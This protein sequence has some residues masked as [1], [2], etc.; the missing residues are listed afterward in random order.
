MSRDS[1]TVALVT[2]VFHDATGAER[3]LAR[4]REA[5]AQ[6]AELAI[7][8]EL[9]LN[10]WCPAR[11]TPDE[12]DAE[13]PEGPRQQAM[14]RAARAAGLALLGGAIVRDPATG[15]RHNTAILFDA[16]G[17]VLARYAK[18]HVPWEEGYWEADHYEAG[19]D[20]PEP[21]E[22]GG[23]PVGIQICS[24]VNRPE[25]THALGARGAL[26]VLA[27]RATPPQTWERWRI[28]LRANAVTSCLYVVSVN[29]PDPLLAQWVPSEP[30]TSIGGPSLVVAPDGNVVAE[31]TDA[32]IIATLER[33]VVEAARRTYPGYLAVRSDLYA[34][35]WSR[36]PVA[37]ARS[38]ASK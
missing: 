2:D 6:G 28:V 30:G 17:A 9:P 11:R 34:R 21:V 35:A 19:A 14:A 8:P 20:L 1:L 29:R 37:E 23:F 10:S 5:R 12:N 3:L 24:D 38:A 16:H 13:P 25:A 32:V 36:A 18:L 26:A 7:L 15:K 31:G 22:M 33:S 4:L 27:P